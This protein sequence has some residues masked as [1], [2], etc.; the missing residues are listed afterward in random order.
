MMLEPTLEIPIGNLTLRNPLILAAGI[1]GTSY[2]AIK[3]VYQSGFGAMVS[4]SIGPEPNFGYKNPTIILLP[5]IHSAI[6]AVGLANPGALDFHDKMLKN[7][8]DILPIVYSIYGSE[9]DHIEH[10]IQTLNDL[11]PLAYELNVSCPHG[12]KF[13]LQVCHDD[14]LF[15]EMVR[16]AK[17]NATCPIWVKL[18]PNA[19]N[20]TEFADIAIRGG[21]DALVAINTLKAMVIDIET[22][23]PILA[24]KSGGLSGKAVKPVGVRAI[25]DLYAEYGSKVPIIGV[26]GISSAEDVIEYMLAGASAVQIGTAFAYAENQDKFGHEILEDLKSYLL[27]K[28]LSLRDLI[29]KA[30]IET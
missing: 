15:F 8:E 2:S 23:Q 16:V 30:H 21:A 13:G 11:N 17:R 12:G 3:R 27:E 7:K 18:S 25:Y 10:I 4:K 28:Q 14:S 1:L 24:N 5:E 19:I 26:G 9:I 20:I 6:N 22:M 29:G